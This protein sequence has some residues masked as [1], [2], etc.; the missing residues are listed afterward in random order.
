MRMARS[1]GLVFRYVGGLGR[2]L[3][4]RPLAALIAVCTSPAAPSMLRLSSNC[5][6]MLVDPS[7]LVEVIWA[8][9]GMAANFCSSGVATEAAMVSGLAPG[10]L[11]VYRYGRKVNCWK[12]CHR[13]ELI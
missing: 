8:R 5:S 11:R 10:K 1:A 3:G 13:Q 9:P 4:N 6:V 7:P 12:G 2:S